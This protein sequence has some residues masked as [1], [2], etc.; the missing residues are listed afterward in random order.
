LGFNKDIRRYTKVKD[1]EYVDEICSKCINRLNDKDLCNIRHCID[2]NVRCEN[3]KIKGII[4]K[5][6]KKI[7]YIGTLK[8]LFKKADEIYDEDKYA[9]I[10]PRKEV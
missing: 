7:E 4:N 2:G 10:F 6:N 9:T 3:E 1:K 5:D 8:G